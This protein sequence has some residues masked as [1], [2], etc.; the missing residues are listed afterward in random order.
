ML[1]NDL[2]IF[3]NSI[4]QYK[5]ANVTISIT[6][7]SPKTYFPLLILK[8]QRNFKVEDQYIIQGFKKNILSLRDVC[9]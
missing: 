7:F 6:Y 5:E 4:G 2:L 9:K 3:F 8:Y 1:A